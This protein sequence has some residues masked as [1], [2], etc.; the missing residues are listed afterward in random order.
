VAPCFID[1]T[2]FVHTFDRSSLSRQAGA[3]GLVRDSIGAREHRISTE[4]SHE[5]VNPS[6]RKLARPL[7]SAECAE[8]LESRLLPMCRVRRTQAMTLDALGRVSRYL[9][10]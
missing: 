2:I 10:S 8:C 1:T 4:V 7:T 3:V 5:L 6:L 9:H